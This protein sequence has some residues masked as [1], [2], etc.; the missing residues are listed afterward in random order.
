MGGT[1]SFVSLLFSFDGKVGAGF[2]SDLPE[3]LFLWFLLVIIDDRS[4]TDFF[5]VLLIR[6][7]LHSEGFGCVI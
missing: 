5:K 2:S 7:A 6:T 3:L 4:K 1:C